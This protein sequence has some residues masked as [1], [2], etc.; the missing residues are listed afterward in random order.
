M[1]RTI[2]IGGGI[3]G[4]STAFHLCKGGEEAIVFDR[5]D[6]GRATDAGAG[7]ISPET[8]RHEQEAFYTLG[9]QAAKYYPRLVSAV[10]DHGVTETV[11][12]QPGALVI[13]PAF[14]KSEQ[15]SAGESMIIDRQARSGHPHGDELYR[16]S[17]KEAKELFPALGGVNR[18]VYYSNG[19]RVDG[20]IFQDALLEAGSALG[21]EIIEENVH[22]LLIDDGEVCGVKSTN[23]EYS[24]TN[25]V[26]AGGAWSPAFSEQLDQPL[27]IS[28]Q[29]GQIIHLALSEAATAEWPIVN[30]MEGFYLVPWED[31]RVAAGA[32]REEGSGFSP[33]T[34]AEGVHE[35]LDFTLKM[36]PG[37]ADGAIDDIRVGLRPV[38]TDGLPVL[39]ESSSI[40]GAFF[41]TGHGP[42][43]LTLGPYSGKCVAD[44]ILSNTTDLDMSPYAPD[45]FQQ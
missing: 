12:G 23:D 21:L 13:D 38:S 16:V 37:L 36:A 30:T 44:E 20:R 24:A 32:T 25:V 29:R 43:G 26:I 31:G 35:V 45:R 19:A 28:P 33:Q 7:I 2:V 34:T 41:A 17:G 15:Y 6:K 4:A 3:V 40:D 9:I 8:S 27:P 22:S 14:T 1:S 39:G 10:K 42:S 11:Y 5:R 18:G